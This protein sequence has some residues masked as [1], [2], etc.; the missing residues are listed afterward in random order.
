MIEAF[1]TSC[2]EGDKNTEKRYHKHF[3]ANAWKSWAWTY[4]SVLFSSYANISVKTMKMHCY[5]MIFIR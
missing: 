2:L 1:I 4:I 3:A 5:I